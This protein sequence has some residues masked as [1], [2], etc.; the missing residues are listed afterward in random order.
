MWFIEQ[1]YYFYIH[2][3]CTSWRD[4]CKRT[5]NKID[6]SLILSRNHFKLC[7]RVGFR[8]IFADHWRRIS[9]LLLKAWLRVKIPRFSPS[10]ACASVFL[11]WLVQSALHLLC[12]G[13]C[14]VKQ[15][16]HLTP[17]IFDIS[18]LISSP[19]YKQPTL[20]KLTVVH[21]REHIFIN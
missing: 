8:I 3:K 6:N 1:I 17:Q 15:V 10:L 4:L 20:C 13:F 12:F 18:G 19:S 14:H 11:C 16:V 2:Y 21:F 9:A 5:E 7:K